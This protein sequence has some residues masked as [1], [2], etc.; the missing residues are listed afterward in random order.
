M[1]SAWWEHRSTGLAAKPAVRVYGTT[2]VSSLYDHSGIHKILEL[3]TEDIARQAYVLTPV[4]TGRLRSTLHP[5]FVDTK[6]KGGHIR[7]GRVSIGEG[8]DY[9]LKIEFGSGAGFDVGVGAIK[10]KYFP[11]T[12]KAVQY[13]RGAKENRRAVTNG[14]GAMLRRGAAKAAA[15]FKA[16]GLGTFKRYDIEEVIKDMTGKVK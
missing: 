5:S 2:R 13:L 16:S 4:K 1:T 14:K 11:V 10:Q 6:V 8:L 12:P 9:A 3:V 15:R 7:R